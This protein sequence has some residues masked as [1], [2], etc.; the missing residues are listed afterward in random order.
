MV[1][2]C[3]NRRILA[4]PVSDHRDTAAAIQVIDDVLAKFMKIPE[5]LTLVLDGHL[6]YLLAQYFF[7]QRDIHFKVEWVIGLKN[8]D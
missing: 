5:N 6:L 1:I 7:T 2:D 3:L 8:E 4:F